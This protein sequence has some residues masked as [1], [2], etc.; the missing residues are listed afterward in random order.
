M[1]KITWILFFFLIH[2]AIEAKIY[3]HEKSGFWIEIPDIWAIQEKDDRI[4]LSM[5]GKNLQGELKILEKQFHQKEILENLTHSLTPFY[6]N[7][8]IEKTL[9][10]QKF[11]VNGIEARGYAEGEADKEIYYFVFYVFACP[12]RNDYLT[13]TFI[14]Y[15]EEFKKMGK[16]I[17]YIIENIRRI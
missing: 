13:I 7:P 16:N 11:S 8:V 15:P 17:F 5:P 3:R 14:G 4:L 9:V 10:F 12:F 2:I 1:K 6:K